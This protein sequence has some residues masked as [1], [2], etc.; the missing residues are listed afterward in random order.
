MGSWT[1]GLIMQCF[2]ILTLV[3]AGDTFPFYIPLWLCKILTELPA[4]FTCSERAHKQLLG[5][6]I[7]LQHAGR[8]EQPVG[9]QQ[10]SIQLLH[11]GQSQK[12][13]K[14]QQ[15]P[16]WILLW[17]MGWTFLYLMVQCY[18]DQNSTNTSQRIRPRVFRSPLGSD[19]AWE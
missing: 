14:K 1:Q 17:I 2:W 19:A 12:A 16:L 4:L 7:C 8:M 6:V 13:G 10:S 9:V 15:W 18:G 11:T 3:I 5:V